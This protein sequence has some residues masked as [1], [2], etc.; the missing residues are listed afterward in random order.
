PPEHRGQSAPARDAAV[1]AQPDGRGRR[2]RADLHPQL[3][4][5]R[6]RPRHPGADQPAQLIRRDPAGV[7]ARLPGATLRS[8]VVCRPP[9][10]AV[11]GRIEVDQDKL[12]GDARP[13]GAD[14]GLDSARGLDRRGFLMGAATG[15]AAFAVAGAQAQTGSTADGAAPAVPPPTA[16]Q[17][18][19]AAGAVR[20]PAVPAR[21]AVRPG[22]DLMVQV[23]KELSIEFVASNPGSSFEGLQE[24]IVNYG[25]PPNRM[26]EF[27]TA[28]HEESAVDMANG[29]AKA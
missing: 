8:A 18:E 24:S 12:A 4:G 23:L 2:R 19:R 13:R 11:R 22:S 5:Q 17:V 20:P 26:P 10:P 3:M 1:R 21:A 14:D 7:T 16:R 9:R 15:A 28:L 6:S 25:N 27:I 29:Y